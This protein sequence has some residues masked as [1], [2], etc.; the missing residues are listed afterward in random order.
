MMN[1][2]KVVFICVGVNPC[3]Q[4]ASTHFHLNTKPKEVAN[5]ES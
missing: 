5:D 2:I 1:K 4:L 3:N